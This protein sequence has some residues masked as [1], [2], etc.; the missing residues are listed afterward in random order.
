[1]VKYYA[2]KKLKCKTLPSLG[3]SLINEK[4]VVCYKTGSTIPDLDERL[5]D[6]ARGRHHV[7]QGLDLIKLLFRQHSGTV[8]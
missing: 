1:M 5:G 2:R 4:N 3:R 6:S 8:S 7:L